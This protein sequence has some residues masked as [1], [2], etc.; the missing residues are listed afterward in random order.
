[1]TILSKFIPRISR[2]IIN[3]VVLFLTATLISVPAMSEV[4]MGPVVNPAN[5]HEYY[6]LEEST[7]TEAEAEAVVLDGHLVTI[8]DQAEQDWVW[9]TFSGDES[10]SLWTGFNDVEEEET[11]VWVSGEPVTYTNWLP[12]EPNH[13]SNQDY[14]EMDHF[15]NG[16]W[17]DRTYGW[18]G[19][20]H[21]VVEV[22]PLDIFT[23][24]P[25][26]PG[27]AG[28]VNTWTTING[29]PDRRM[30]VFFCKAF[31]EAQVPIAACAH[32]NLDFLFARNLGNAVADAEGTA[33]YERNVS[34]MGEGATW[35]FQA[36][37]VATCELTDVVTTT[38]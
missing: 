9:S 33:H 30:V 26:D 13:L 25:V 17:H 16:M 22:V 24:L 12:G 29:T 20:T 36:I 2:S 31:G 18:Y 10:R 34:A 32:V 28:G 7:W 35:H 3:S 21:G 5:D 11:F 4:I 37:D 19:P 6:L 14:V 38:F 1:M 8:N 23:L 15:D 27:Q